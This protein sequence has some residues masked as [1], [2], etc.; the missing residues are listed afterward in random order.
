[1][2]NC[3]KSKSERLKLKASKLRDESL[4]ALSEFTKLKNKTFVELFLFFQ[5]NIFGFEDWYKST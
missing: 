3:E 4:D 1:M 2:G 5:F